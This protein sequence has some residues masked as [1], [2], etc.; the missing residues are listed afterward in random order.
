MEWI[1]NIKSNVVIIPTEKDN[2]DIQE[3]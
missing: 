3:L 2:N 1:R